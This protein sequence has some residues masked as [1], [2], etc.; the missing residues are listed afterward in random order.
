MN[1]LVLAI[2]LAAVLQSS[3]SYGQLPV[4]RLS[5]IFP[6]GSTSGRTVEVAVSGLD[7][8]DV[9]R[10]IF[11]HD[12]I[13]SAPKLSKDRARPE[14]N[15]FVLT[16]S[17]HIPPGIYEARAIGR[18]GMTNPRAFV[19]S[20]RRE[21]IEPAQNH[22]R[23]SPAALELESVM[24]G[25]ADANAADFF[26]F[27]AK[28]GQRL[29]IECAVAAIDSRMDPVLVLYGASGRELDRNRRGGTLDLT[30]QSDSL[31]ILKVHDVLYRGGEEYFYRLSI[32][33]A[34][35]LDFILPPCGLAGTKSK[36]DLYGRNLPGGIPTDF[37]VHGKTLEKL[38]VE[39]D[40]PPE[41]S[42]KP[43]AFPGIVLK[44]A[45]AVINGIEYQLS[46]PQGSSNPLL[47]SFATAP[48]VLEEGANDKGES[49][50]KVTVPCEYVGQF[51]PKDDRDWI[52]FEAKKG[53]AYWVEIFSHRL[54]LPTD[55]F[56]LI[57]R[58]AEDEKGGEKISDV[59]ELYDLDANL[60]GPEF[61]T[62]TRDAGARFEAKES[63]TYRILARDLFNSVE[64]DPRLIYRLAIRKAAPDFRLVA[65]PQPP[66]PINRDKREA[67][68]WALFLRKG[69]TVA[70]KVLAF[71]REGFNGEI[72]LAVEGLPP[73]V[74]A[75]DVQIEPNKS[76]AVVL[77]TA[78]ENAA[79]WNGP[80]RILGKASIGATE[81]VREARE[82]DVNWTV[83]DY[84]SEPVT[85]R[86]RGDLMLAVSDQEA[87]PVS[88]FAAEEK[89]WETSLA[90]K[91]QIPLK[92]QRRGEFNDTIKLKAAGLSALDPMKEVD[93]ANS[94][95]AVMLSLDLTQLKVPVGVHSFHLQ[96]Q[97]K[98]KYRRRTVEEA[99]SAE[100][101]AKAAEDAAKRTEKEAADLAAAA[102][103]AS[104]ALMLAKQAAEEAETRAKTTQ[105]K[106]A[107][108]RK[109][110]EQTSAGAEL[111]ESKAAV[112]KGVDDA[113]ALA[114][115]AVAARMAAEQSFME[116]SAKAKEA[117]AR[118]EEA[119]KQAKAAK[120]A[121]ERAQLKDLTLSTYSAS[122]HLKV[123]AAPI[124]IEAEAPSS[125]VEQGGKIAI[126]I[127]VTR[128]Y[129]FD[130]AVELG[131][132]VPKGVTGL[133]IPK[134]V[135]S[136]DES[137][138][139]LV[140]EAGNDATL[141]DHTLTLQASVKL[142]NQDLR[143]ELPL[144]L[145]V[146]FK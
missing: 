100:T 66:P 107:S 133:K 145:K 34:P 65:L 28:K 53:E 30:V 126:P 88:I 69:E 74:R 102:K 52:A 51:H 120:E 64:S 45:D 1:G 46:A 6:P 123:G 113:L 125:P 103:K 99:K 92:V 129:G 84:N 85:S 101:S 136:K 78:A 38:A 19:V 11:S 4:A 87:A 20:D 22:S 55:P 105:E 3:A 58:V 114:K 77:L 73:G 59:Q 135:I 48:V 36:F 90:G 17:S 57:Q 134:G 104:E 50:Q 61:N 60:G 12:G 115:T 140:V 32:S 47:I 132:A 24:N 71:R 44:P 96:A 75:D 122:I 138:G 15:Q 128:L 25:H 40:L 118:K 10:I 80:I 83:P 94:T 26:K 76:S 86:I 144:L 141:G 49:A 68:P 93:V 98:G 63:G 14:P 13:K 116:A 37:K 31:F 79:G 41:D 143:A 91:L 108:A 54:G 27:S 110:P 33:A 127:K 130:G 117:E 112:E 106:L 62:A 82:A 139:R 142:N 2:V 8:D 137:S 18:F 95:N 29:M 21:I 67:T 124:T 119:A 121:L 42:N 7:L 43:R 39:I 5:A 9:D 56:L 89:V 16:V 35:H 81:A 97:T 23:E 70:V 109:T 111:A 131:A 146:E 72:R